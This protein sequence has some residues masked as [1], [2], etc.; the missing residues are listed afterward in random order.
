MSKIVWET[1]AGSLGV[2]PQDTFYE[3]TISSTCIGGIVKYYVVA[4]K[5]PG[6]MQLIKD[7]IIQ[8]V[9]E[10]EANIV[11]EDS[12]TFNFTIRAIC[13]T[14]TAIADRTFSLTVGSIYNPVITPK[15]I[16]LG[17]YFDGYLLK[18]QLT[19]VGTNPKATMVWSLDHG[20]LPPGVTL[21]EDG[22][23]S[24]NIEP[25]VTSLDDAV[26]GWSKSPFNV[27]PWDSASIGQ[28]R[29]Y[30]FTVK[31]SD[32]FRTDQSS[33]TLNV[34]AK[35]KYTADNT[36]IQ[37]DGQGI[38]VD[39]DNKHTPFMITK[40]SELVS[41]RQN[42]NFAFEFVGKDVDGGQLQYFIINSDEVRFDQDGPN[43][44]QI[45]D[46]SWSGP[47]SE[48]L[49]F[50]GVT[51]GFDEYGFDQRSQVLPSG[52]GLVPSSDGSGW[53]DSGWLFGVLDPQ[54]EEVKEYE[55]QVVCRKKDLPEYVSPPITYK[56]TVLGAM[57]NLIE[58]DTPS[59]LGTIDN[60][61]ISEL[62]I[63]A[64]TTSTAERYIP[65]HRKLNYRI[66]PGRRE[67]PANLTTHNDDA[68][69]ILYIPEER[70]KLP[71]GLQL[72]PNG[73]IVG[74]PTFRHF[75]ID[76]DSTTI[77][78]NTTNFDNVYE[79]TI[80]ATDETSY[81]AADPFTGTLMQEEY[82]G[83]VWDEKTFRI[84][85]N[86][87]NVAPFENIY[88]RAM[89]DK[90]Q[91]TEFNQMINDTSLFPNELIYRP[92]DQ[93]FGKAKHIEFIFAA[94]I[95]PATLHDYALA[96]AN[97]HYKKQ[98][99]LKNV[100]TA[101][102]L[103]ENFNVR[104]EVVYLEVFDNNDTAIDNIHT[105]F[106]VIH[107]NSLGNMKKELSTIGY[108]NRGAMP[109]WMLDPQKNG[110]VLGFTTGIVLAYTKPRASELIAFRL[111]TAANKYN[112]NQV[113][114]SV[115]RYVRDK[116]LSKF[117]DIT[118]K[119]FSASKE[120]TFDRLT[121]ASNVH[122]YAGAVDYALTIP[123]DEVN[124]RT[125]EY[126][127]MRGGLDI[128]RGAKIKSGQTLIFVKQEHFTINPFNDIYDTYDQNNFD[129]IGIDTSSRSD[130]YNSPNNGWNFNLAL[131]DENGVVYEELMYDASGIVPGYFEKI[132]S[133]VINKRAG[134]WKVEITEQN[135][136]MLIP[137]FRVNVE[138][139]ELYDSVLPNEYVQ[140]ADGGRYGF[141]KMYYDVTIK[142]GNTVPEY[143]VLASE[144]SI[145]AN[146]TRF[147]SG[148]TKFHNYRDII[149]PPGTDDQ[150]VMFP[151]K[152]KY[153]QFLLT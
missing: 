90:K 135:V 76:G 36:Y 64:R 112:F 119:Q 115:D 118:V 152:N 140:V 9:P 45:V 88:L 72:L 93:W 94:G 7:G 113:D 56:L 62:F 23:L 32:G 104:Y 37:I 79:F 128:G 30:N 48:D 84:R 105:P 19:A 95:A 74:R 85:V 83:T 2:I 28:S 134:I 139:G 126:I 117:Y 12:Y 41:Q 91:R 18:K 5:L 65:L 47:N 82:A 16:S 34:V 150:Y 17:T 15:N 54:I 21:T 42:S 60:G 123:F 143:T 121:S 59:D 77:D 87:W 142:P 71:Q 8:G 148:A 10:I 122:G 136:V 68:P 43:I 141:T 50:D 138:T 35:G 14:A 66:K 145:E 67:L 149:A 131:Y 52:V 51:V 61:R 144:P 103:D 25:Y 86:N 46:N 69:P 109:D 101:V 132:L 39:T 81:V 130:G 133:G 20:D 70:S 55:F 147:D 146:S 38:T 44:P 114:F 137:Q 124:G 33:Y 49:P 116:Y 92:E 4:G 13:D 106:T 57:D 29:V 125:L 75:T 80:V 89:P 129:K 31:V 111:R 40:P 11:S 27:T 151:K 98:V 100:K 58:W 53:S 63:S 6:G 22:L 107:P 24:G 1:K 108:T 127:E 153:E 78:K 110:R 3:K 26:T 73:L 99:D 120:T 102:A 97:N 96:L